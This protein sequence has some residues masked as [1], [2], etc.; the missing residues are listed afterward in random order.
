MYMRTKMRMQTLSHHN[1]GRT[2]CC[3]LLAYSLQS[4]SG[5][6]FIYKPVNLTRIHRS[7]GMRVLTRPEQVAIPRKG[8]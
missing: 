3:I 8:L 5:A 6:L 7:T 1:H 4:I 2:L